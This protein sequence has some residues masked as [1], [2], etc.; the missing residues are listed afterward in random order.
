MREKL[1]AYV[2]IE[3]I[4][5]EFCEAV[6]ASSVECLWCNCRHPITCG[7]LE[8]AG[9]IRRAAWNTNKYPELL[10]VI[11][12]VSQILEERLRNNNDIADEIL[13]VIAYNI[14]AKNIAPAQQKIR[15]L[16]R[17]YKLQFDKREYALNWLREDMKFKTVPGWISALMVLGREK[18][19]SR[20]LCSALN[21]CNYFLHKQSARGKY[22]GEIWVTFDKQDNVV[23]KIR[24]KIL[25][26]SYG[27]TVKVMK[28]KITP[29]LY[30]ITQHNSK[31]ATEDTISKILNDYGKFTWNV[32]DK[33]Q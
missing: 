27:N 7:M 22:S 8:C 1:G 14:F 24:G 31:K 19:E 3:Q 6:I 17:T 16:M 28:F 5:Q 20:A 12:H 29:E 9:D 33:C 18:K 4:K 25:I 30:Q 23:I 15:T 32:D 26:K 13:P 10:F 21:H 11:Y 2:S